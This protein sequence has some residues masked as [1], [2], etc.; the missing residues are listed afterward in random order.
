M[1]HKMRGRWLVVTTAVVTILLGIV[2]LGL[3][4]WLAAL[5]GSVYYL[6]AGLGLVASG[7][8]ILRGRR[9]G[10][11]VYVAVLAATV[12][13]ALWEAGLDGWALIPR[14]VAPAV[15]GL[16]LCTPWIAGRLDRQAGVTGSAATWR[17]LAGMAICALLIAGVFAAG[18]ATTA[19]RFEQGSP[20]PAARG[21]ALATDGPSD[22]WRYYGRSA[23]GERF[24]PQTQITPQNVS[25]LKPAWSFSTGDLPRAGENSRGREFS[26]EATPIKVG[27]SLYFCTP[28]HDVVALDATTGKQ[29]WRYV[30]GGDMSKNIYQACRGVSYFDAP[31]G[32]A[33]PHR[34]IATESATPKLFELDAD[35]GKLCRSFGQGGAV[36]LRD[37]LGDVP[38]GFHF[39]SSPPLVMNNR[40]MLSGWVYDDQSVQEPSGVV[41]AFDAVTGKLSW[42]WDV[43]RSPTNRPLGKNEIFTRGTP[44]AWGVYTA[45]PA[46]NL[47]YIPT[48]IATP[49]YFGG[50]RRPF[51]DKYNTSVVALDMTTGL[52]RWHFQLVHHD[53]WDFDVPIGPS[54]VDL[55]GP[56]GSTIPALVQTSKQGQL[57]LLD[58]R[59]GHPIAKV[60]ERPVPGGHLPGERYAPTQPFSVGMPNLTPPKMVATKTWGMTP[61]DQALCRI[62]LAG[63]RND[64][65]FT[66]SGLD[67]PVL[68]DPAFDGVMDWYGGTIDPVRKLLYTNSMEMPFVF[69]TYT[70]A[71][72]LKKKLFKP[73]AGWG[74]PYPQPLFNNNP[75]HG[76][77]YAQVVKPWLG[78]FGAPCVAPPW[79]TL[80][81]IDL[82][83][84][85]VVWSRPVGTTANMGPHNFR[86]PFGLPTGIFMM[87]GNIATASG[88]VFMGATSDQQFR[89]FD[90]RTGRTLW[91]T[92]LPAGG[93]ATPLSYTGRD[94]RQYVV[95]AAGGHGGLRSRNG[96]SV[97]AFALPKAAQ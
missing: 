97:I 53:I 83:A 22:D 84:R 89:A 74:H 64:G 72:A 40:I 47:V 21:A 58:R 27:D 29:R 63:M 2:L 57:F 5:G 76:L 30:A 12:V 31:A 93:N 91:S 62:E 24:A 17:S 41:R 68:G 9:S 90:A 18:Y 3:G 96:D 85:K 71:D 4:G 6:L 14:I 46:L 20:Y 23:G 35:T 82:V 7:V 45:D 56:N 43:G 42:A 37:G 49:D 48:G 34:I 75:Q 26:F 94:G 92:A 70:R 44:N 38:P 77:P 80:K 32:Q 19:Q 25:Q 1:D 8:L 52:E 54:L 61:I 36:D 73:W 60:E 15:L 50:R 69:T 79:G 28:H 65:L 66:P 55:P 95:I 33:C 51:D 86:I 39:I 59:N 81:A 13:W 87:G 10:I 16:W 67:K 11:H 88:L 78:A